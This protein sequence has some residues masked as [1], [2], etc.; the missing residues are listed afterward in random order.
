MLG[1]RIMRISSIWTSRGFDHSES[2][3]NFSSSLPIIPA[4]REN[5]S[6]ID[7]RSLFALFGL[8]F[9]FFRLI[10]PRESPLSGCTFENRHFELGLV[11]AEEVL[12]EVVLDEAVDF[13]LQHF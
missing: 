13:V 10:F 8:M 11:E 5:G 6:I 12:V 9:T 4:L 3:L 2:R 7:W 1:P